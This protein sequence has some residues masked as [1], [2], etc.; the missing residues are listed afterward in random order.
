MP[1]FSNIQE[2]LSLE[3]LKNRFAT[4]KEAFR[5][6]LNDLLK[7]CDDKV[8]MDFI[9]RNSIAVKSEGNQ[10]IATLVSKIIQASREALKRLRDNNIKSLK[11]AHVATKEEADNKALKLYIIIRQ[12]ELSGLDNDN[13]IAIALNKAKVPTP[14]GKTNWQQITVM[15]VRERVAKLQS[16]GQ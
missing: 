15:R 16:P 6:D 2:E 12:Y 5:I 9:I 8:R 3:H 4:E 14:R 11:R 13:A 10:D 1:D 7:I